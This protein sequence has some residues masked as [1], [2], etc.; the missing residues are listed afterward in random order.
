MHYAC[1]VVHT[2]SR[3]T[4]GYPSNSFNKKY[5][6]IDRSISFMWPTNGRSM[7]DDYVKPF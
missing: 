6:P 1:N 5:I 3:S 2:S 4:T 7:K